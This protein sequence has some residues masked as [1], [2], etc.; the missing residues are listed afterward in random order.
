[1]KN[2]HEVL[3]QKEIDLTRVRQE[4]DA[5]RCVAPMLNEPQATQPVVSDP[6]CRPRN[7]WPLQ[8]DEFP[9]ASSDE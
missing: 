1:M 5:L 4:V 3:R 6:E 9:P 2:V 8:I 7:R